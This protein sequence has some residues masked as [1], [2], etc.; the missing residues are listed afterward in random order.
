MLQS[1]RVGGDAGQAF[2]VRFS[3]ARGPWRA[4]SIEKGDGMS[5]SI[6]KS[7]DM[8]SG[9][10]VERVQEIPELRSQARIFSHQTTGARCVHLFNE[11]PNNLFCIAFRTP[12]WNNTGVPHILEHSVL[13][14]SAK[15]PLKDPF[16]ELLKG[17]LQTFLNALTYP[18]KT[19]YPVSS[20][21]E[22][23]FFH[24][25]DVYCDAVFHPLLTEE[26]F[27]QEGWHFDVEDPAGPVNIKGIVYNEMKG[28]F[29]DFRSHVAR[30]TLSHL[31]PDT[32]YYFE[33]GGE[34]EHIPNLSY[35][36]FVGFHRKYYHP[37]NSFIFLYGNV[38]SERTLAFLNDGYL[39]DFQRLEVDSA[40]TLQKPWSR[41]AEVSFEAPASKEQ[42]GF[43]SVILSW[44]WG[45]ST[46]ALSALLGRVFDHYLLGTQS[47]PLRRALIDSGLGEDLEDMCGFDGDLGQGIFSAG[48]RKTKAEHA[49]A[50]RTLVLDTL[51]KEIAGGLDAELLEGSIRQIEFRLREIT[52][53]GSFPFGLMLAER[54][55][56]SWIY[57]GD[58]LVHLC[59]EEPLNRIKAEKKLGTKFFVEKLQELLVDNSHC[60]LSVIIA[61]H[62][63][64]KALEKQTEE[65]A[66]RLSE[67][68]TAQD[69]LRYHEL[70][71]RLA[72]SQQE[73]TPPE[74]MAKIPKLH[75]AD[76]PAENR[77]TPTTQDSVAG[78]PWYMHPLF[79]SGIVYLDIGFDLAAVPLD[80][81]PYF[82]LYSELLT[83][84]GAAGFSYEEMAKRISLA[85][86]GIGS[87]DVCMTSL[88]GREGELTFKCFVHGKALPERF[89]EMLGILQD[90]FTKPDLRNPKQIKEILF[91]MRN[92]LNASVVSSGHNF[93]IGDASAHI[94]KSQYIG[95]ILDGLH[96]LR[97]LNGLLKREAY[98]Q[99]IAAMQRLH[100]IIINRGTCFVSMTNDAPEKFRPALERFLGS[101]PAP[102]VKPVPIEFTPAA[103]KTVRAVEISS[104]V[105]FVARSWRLQL[106][107]PAAI[108]EFVLMARNLSTGYLW[109]TIRVAGG[110]YGGMALAAGT[111]PIFSC[112]SYRDPNLSATLR[113][114]E[115]GFGSL[116]RGVPA[117]EIEQ[118]IVGT[119]GRI[120]KPQAPHSRGFGETLA[121]LSGRS[122]EH[123]QAIREAILAMTPQ[124]LARAARQILEEPVSAAT[125]LGS[126]AAFDQA[127]KE[128]VSLSRE[129]L[130]PQEAKRT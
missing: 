73:K 120:D 23:D 82:P 106:A 44:L 28:V 17:S 79:T 103:Q 101:L 114:F 48:L 25:V 127:Q 52:D 129:P 9:F 36:D 68:F 33:S 121:L 63:K 46:D 80:L 112:A 10:R 97:F 76:L 83:R 7:G 96:Q 53:S 123:R 90:L 70:T 77:K 94:E 78:V 125:V 50:I 115:E 60:L 27:S 61:S 108:G 57:G 34:P 5:E 113:K 92:D 64:G 111:H 30:K 12:V 47:S 54:C 75:L 119:I 55:Y 93:A 18:D 2:C 102:G 98:D 95:E 40:I 38:P 81:L 24:L 42:D 51:R 35:A 109:E 59:F 15:F 66:R 117:E 4:Y 3:G 6:M 100:G 122:P 99:V 39:K 31:L 45:N 43:A 8:L 88:G 1:G 89:E 84:C 105:N 41:P 74:V 58:P 67:G 130:F 16:K 19:I 26:T 91:E 20:Q 110:A 107:N 62:E 71:K 104:S 124:K 49:E 86:G 116:A 69:K 72:A 87:S 14:G 56:R 126:A 65:Q 11:E 32:T 37:S 29:S 13:A 85:S 22:A 128:G 21:V 118:S